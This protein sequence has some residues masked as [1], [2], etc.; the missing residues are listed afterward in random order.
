MRGVDDRRTDGDTACE[1]R[2]FDDETPL[3]NIR[4]CVY[5]TDEMRGHENVIAVRG[6]VI[7]TLYS[8]V[9]LA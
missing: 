4:E 8:S 2:I 9:R 7:A 1:S 3:V 6:V 5:E